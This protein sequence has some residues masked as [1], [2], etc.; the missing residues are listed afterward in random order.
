MN[1]LQDILTPAQRAKVYAIFGL[2]SLTLTATQVAFLAIP[3]DEPTWLRVALAVFTFVSGA[4]GFTAK[5]NTP[6]SGRHAT[7]AAE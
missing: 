1:A 7:D 6:A 5:A 2:L 4:V 3:L